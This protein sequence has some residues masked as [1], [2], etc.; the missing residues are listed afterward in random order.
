MIRILQRKK[1][2]LTHKCF[3][4]N[5]GRSPFYD[6]QHQGMQNGAAIALIFNPLFAGR[7]NLR[8]NTT[9]LIGNWFKEYLM[10]NFVN[11]RRIHYI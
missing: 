6:F 8:Y 3:E 10:Q 9:E 2:Y 7:L 11:K 1:H 5:E 4:F